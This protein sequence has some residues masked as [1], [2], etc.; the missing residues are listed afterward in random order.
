M[1]DRKQSWT[2]V[3]EWPKEPLGAGRTNQQFLTTAREL[4]GRLKTSYSW[5]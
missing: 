5:E 3:L 2:V 1:A 4:Q